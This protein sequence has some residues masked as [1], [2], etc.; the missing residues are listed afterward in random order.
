MTLLL[1]KSTLKVPRSLLLMPSMHPSSFSCSTLCSSATVCTCNNTPEAL[2]HKPLLLTLDSG[3]SSGSRSLM[4]RVLKTPCR[5]S[6]TD[7]G[8]LIHL[9]SCDALT[10]KYS[11]RQD[12]CTMAEMHCL[13]ALDTNCILAVYNNAYTLYSLPTSHQV[14]KH[15]A[16]C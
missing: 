14:Q 15:N 3:I 1:C 16:G 4:A 13:F 6:A 11:A 9:A 12:L 5:L 2:T 7:V 10:H 8:T